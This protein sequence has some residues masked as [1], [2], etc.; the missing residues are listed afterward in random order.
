MQRNRKEENKKVKD[1]NI[2]DNNIEVIVNIGNENNDESEQHSNSDNYTETP[3]QKNI[4]KGLKQNE[5]DMND[6]LDDL[7]SK[8]QEFNKKKEQLINNKIDI[9]NNIFNLP[10]I[11]INSRDDVL[12]LMDVLNDKINSLNALLIKPQPLMNQLTFQRSPELNVQP[13]QNYIPFAGLRAAD[14]YRPEPY[15]TGEFISDRDSQNLPPVQQ[16]GVPVVVEE[17]IIESVGE[18]VVVEEEEVIGVGPV[19]VPELPR[20]PDIDEFGP[21]PDSDYEDEGDESQV[22]PEQPPSEYLPILNNRRAILTQYINSAKP[23][24]YPRSRNIR[25]I[26]SDENAN[27]YNEINKG[28]ANIDTLDETQYNYLM[29]LFVVQD[30]TIEGSLPPAVAY[31]HYTSEP[32]DLR[33]KD[34]QVELRELSGGTLNNPNARRIF[35]LIINNS[36]IPYYFFTIEGDIYNESDEEGDSSLAP[37]GGDSNNPNNPEQGPAQEPANLN[38][39]FSDPINYQGGSNQIDDFFGT[40]DSA[41]SDLY[42]FTNPGNW[43]SSP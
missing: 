15:Q 34:L 35:N 28:I 4:N 8:I 21:E 3:Q 30:T 20:Q 26:I 42:E 40:A 27:V 41:F 6:L 25:K 24:D 39:V 18:P 10:D 1:K 9:P 32:L 36:A 13:Q 43:F 2:K 38:P 22:I 23:L 19:V 37:G 14:F 29:N 16:V 12:R 5:N 31:R 17:E 7:K 33:N 11:E